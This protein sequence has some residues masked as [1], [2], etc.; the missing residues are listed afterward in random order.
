[1]IDLFDYIICYNVFFFVAFVIFTTLFTIWK[2]SDWINVVIKIV[3]MFMAIWA[4]IL[5]LH[6]QKYIIKVK[7][8]EV[9][10]EG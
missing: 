6:D 10:V 2:R 7:D 4:G 3:L 5:F 1:M 9:T 8:V